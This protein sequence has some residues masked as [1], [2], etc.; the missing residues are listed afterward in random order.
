MN[1][2]DDQSSATTYSC[3]YYVDHPFLIEA[4]QS[5][6]AFQLYYYSSH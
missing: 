3:Y 5:P 4:F 2:K 1:L 6:K